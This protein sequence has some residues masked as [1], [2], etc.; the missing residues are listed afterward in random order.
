MARKDFNE[1]LIEEASTGKGRPTPK[2]REQEAAHQRAV[3]GGAKQTP[4]ER[5]AR[6]RDQRAKEQQAMMSGDE[7][8][9]PAE[10]RGPERRYMRDYIDART[11]LGEYALP[12]SIL[13]VVVSLFFNSTPNVGNWIILAFY[14]L[15]FAAIGDTMWAMRTLRKRMEEKF[16]PRGM[17]RGWRLY[18]AARIMKLRRL[19]VPKPAV[20]RGEYPV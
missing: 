11:S 10:H 3:I 1:E 20:K 12:G 6:Q 16:G 7:R 8:H 13:F 9:M 15:V 4:K 19:R 18:T 14:A 5:R 17:T 2:R